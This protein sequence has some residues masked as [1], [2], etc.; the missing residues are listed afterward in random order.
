MVI[1]GIFFQ[2]VVVLFV[3]ILVFTHSL[4]FL[5]ICAFLYFVGCFVWNDRQLFHA[6]QICFSLILEPLL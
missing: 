4:L 6:M 2:F 1:F 5:F 3:F